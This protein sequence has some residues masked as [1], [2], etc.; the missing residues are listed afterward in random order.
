M[1]PAASR[2]IRPIIA[3]ADAPPSNTNAVRSGKFRIA[4][5]DTENVNPL[6]AI[7]RSIC[8]RVTPLWAGEHK[9]GL[10]DHTPAAAVCSDRIS[11]L[12]SWNGGLGLRTPSRSIGPL[13]ETSRVGSDAPVKQ[14]LD[15]PPYF[16][17]TVVARS[18]A[19]SLRASRPVQRYHRI[20]S[21]LMRNG[22]VFN[23]TPPGCSAGISGRPPRTA[24]RDAC[25]SG[26][27]SSSGPGSATMRPPDT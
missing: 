10:G 11:G 5:V 27:W 23:Q 3:M 7:N 14:V 20:P 1:S 26:L 8:L 22:E 18:R 2:W 21:G 6:R 15:Q 17:Q 12:V 9:V 24:E 16:F 25:V 13:F 19:S 4:V